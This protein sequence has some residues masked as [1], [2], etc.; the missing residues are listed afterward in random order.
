MY[1][2]TLYS[3]LKA[4]H[5]IYVKKLDNTHYLKNIG[6]LQLVQNFISTHICAVA[7]HLNLEFLY[8]F[9]FVIDV[10]DIGL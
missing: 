4:S 10:D 2:M 8:S 5:L 1:K 3:K 9:V 6:Q 7:E